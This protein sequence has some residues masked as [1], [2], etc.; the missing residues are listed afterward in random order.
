MQAIFD[1]P[2]V[3]RFTADSNDRVHRCENGEAKPYGE[4]ITTYFQACDEFRA[5]MSEWAQAVFS[6]RIAFDRETEPSNSSK[7]PWLRCCKLSMSEIPKPGAAASNTTER[8]AV[9][10]SS[11]SGRCMGKR[12]TGS[13]ISITWSHLRRS[14]SSIALIQSRICG[15]CAQTAMLFCTPAD[16]RITSKR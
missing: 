8:I 1:F 4:R 5:F 11:A 14:G 16:L 15:P 3:Q 9:Y 13:S 2:A 7:A 6:G 10:V 12:W